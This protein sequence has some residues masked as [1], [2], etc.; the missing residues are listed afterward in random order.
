M[1]Y[2]R[3]SRRKSNYKPGVPTKRK[4]VN[5]TK[6]LVTGQGPTLLEQIASYAGPVASVA[7]AVL[8]VIGAINTEAKFYDSVSSGA[9]TFAAP[10]FFNM[11]ATTQG[12]T[13]NNR[14]GNSILSKNI[15]CR[16]NLANTWT[17]ADDG[18]WAR[19]RYVIFVDK[20]QAGSVPTLAQLMTNT[21]SLN[22]PFNKNYTDRFVILK[23]KMITFNPQDRLVP[24]GGVQTFIFNKYFKQLDFHTRYIGTSSANADQGQ[25]ALFFFAWYQA[26]TATQTSAVSCYSRLNFTDN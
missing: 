25:N 1:P 23:D 5:K 14:I 17:A 10:V 6:K 20:N 24:A 11:S 9:V 21:T 16:I 26:N 12:T 13:E 7:K 18:Q 3:N 4:Y 15:S 2:K 19:M 22:S 8:P